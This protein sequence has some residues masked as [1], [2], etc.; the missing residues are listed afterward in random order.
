M[1]D[2][3]NLWRNLAEQVDAMSSRERNILTAMIM[4]FAFTI[5]GGLTWYLADLRNDKASRVIAAKGNL[6]EVQALASQ[7]EGLQKRIAVAEAQMG[8]FNPAQF[9]TYMEGWAATA[10]VGEML[11]NIDETNSEVVGQFR[12]RAYKVQVKRAQYEGVLKLM[13]EIE[14]SPYP[15]AVRSAAFRSATFRKEKV[16]D[17]TLELVTYTKEGEEG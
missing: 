7:L 14:T 6:T 2:L 9:R 16:M 15:I 10:G 4:V 3:R 8:E 1:D 13:Y 17:L 5:V 12:E 11:K